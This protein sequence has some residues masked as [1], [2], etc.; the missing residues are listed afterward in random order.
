MIRKLR[1]NP[2]A[3]GLRLCAA[4]AMAVTILMFWWGFAAVASAGYFGAALCMAYIGVVIWLMA[5]D[6]N[7]DDEEVV[8][9]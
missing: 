1:K 7:P 4:G 8:E 2:M 5:K 9:E 6:G 3:E